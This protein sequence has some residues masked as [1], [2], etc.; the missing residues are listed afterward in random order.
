[1]ILFAM[2][3]GRGGCWVGDSV[4]EAFQGRSGK[5]TRRPWQVKY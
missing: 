1:M 3:S 2:I 5:T 4:E